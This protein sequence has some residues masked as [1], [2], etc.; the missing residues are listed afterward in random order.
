MLGKAIWQHL[1]HGLAGYGVG[2]DADFAKLAIRS[3]I[4]EPAHMIVVG[5]GDENTINT[6][7]GLRKDLLSE[8]GSTVDEQSCLRRF[9][10]YAAAQA[11]VVGIGT[12]AY[13]A[14]APY[15]GDA[16]RGTCS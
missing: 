11:P 9:N 16:A 2:I 10:K 12:L 6:A 3:D 14:L 8:I 5:M 15:H 13:R 1:E 7:K 4:V